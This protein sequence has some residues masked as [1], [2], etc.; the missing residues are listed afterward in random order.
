MLGAQQSPKQRHI[1][2]SVLLLLLWFEKS[3]SFPVCGSVYI[4]YI[5]LH[6]PIMREFFNYS[7]TLR[8][9]PLQRSSGPAPRSALKLQPL[10]VD[11]QQSMPHS[12][13]GTHA[14]PVESRDFS[15]LTEAVAYATRHAT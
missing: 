1:S 4:T 7:A 8:V 2:R 13:S 5:V 6:H 12:C 3:T 15:G 9:S 11:G 10:G 14:H